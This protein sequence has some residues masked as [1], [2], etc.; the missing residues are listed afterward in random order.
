MHDEKVYKNPFTFN[1]DCFMGDTP[2]PDPTIL[3]GSFG[4]GRRICPGRYFASDTVFLL[5]ATL[6]WSLEIV[7]MKDKRGEDIIPDAMAYTDHSLMCVH[8]RL[9]L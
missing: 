7:P 6:L 1:P 4:F 9:V 3:G 5:V 2:E 8:P